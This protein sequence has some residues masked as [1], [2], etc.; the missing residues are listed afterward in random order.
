MFLVDR[1]PQD[2]PT[3][4][5]VGG[6]LARKGG[7]LLL[8]AF[9]ELSG[10]ARLLLVTPDDVAAPE[11]VEVVHGATPSSPALIDAYR[12][13]DV[14]CLP[15]RGDCTPVVLGEAMAAGLPAITTRIGSNAETVTDGVE[16]II[17][18]VDDAAELSTA[19]GRLV[20]DPG[21][22]N[23]MGAAARAKAVERYD[24][25]KNAFRILALLRSVAK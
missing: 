2:V 15:T 25:E 4:L 5:F 18:D 20:A 17:I 8:D 19:L 24:A 7:D 13:A 22:R 10:R 12:R 21:L 23:R 1:E 9:R 14:F 3:I 16:G 6:D 11:G